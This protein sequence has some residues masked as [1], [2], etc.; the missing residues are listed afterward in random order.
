MKQNTLVLIKPDGVRRKMVGQILT[1]IESRGLDILHLQQKRL[2]E[3]QATDLYKEHKG[4]WH[5]SRNIKHII[6][7]PVI[8]IEV[9]GDSA[10][11]RCRHIVEQI[12][13][14]NRDVIQLPKNLVHATSEPDKAHEELLSVGLQKNDQTRT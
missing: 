7:G 3:T 6:S 10:V 9:Q 8:T 1:A 12:R 4:K 13:E 14:A 5:F 11:T 2:T